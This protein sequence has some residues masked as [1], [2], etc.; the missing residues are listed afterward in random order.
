MIL[1]SH[2]SCC[3]FES[4]LL[5]TLTSTVSIINTDN[6]SPVNA[7][8]IQRFIPLSMIDNPK[9]LYNHRNETQFCQFPLMQASQNLLSPS[10]F[11]KYTGLTTY[12]TSSPPKLYCIILVNHLNS[13]AIILK[14]PNLYKKEDMRKQIL[15]ES[16][17]YPL[18]KQIEDIF[19][20]LHSLVVLPNRNHTC[21]HKKKKK[22]QDNSYLVLAI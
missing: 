15:H 12:F 14:A 5:R 10:Y 4:N 21:S 11:F 19:C 6:L 2:T 17:N 13:I 8:L 7:V 1:Y 22:T 16:L 18:S 20:F 9:R 3:S